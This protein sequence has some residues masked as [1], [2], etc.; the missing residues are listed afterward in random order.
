M[1]SDKKMICNSYQRHK[2]ENRN[3]YR[4]F[5]VIFESSSKF[6]IV[7]V[8]LII[9]RRGLTDLPGHDVKLT[10]DINLVCS[11]FKGFRLKIQMVPVIF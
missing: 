8:R 6:L 1:T 4:H 3:Y 9:E 5:S 11:D 2:G 7:F 10:S